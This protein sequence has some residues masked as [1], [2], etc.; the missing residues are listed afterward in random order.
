LLW[1]EPARY[2]NPEKNSEWEVTLYAPEDI[3]DGLGMDNKDANK[4]VAML[5]EMTNSGGTVIDV[6]P[7]W[8]S[9]QDSENFVHDWAI[10]SQNSKAD[11]KSMNVNPAQ[12][13]KGYVVFEIPESAAPKSGLYDPIAG[14]GESSLTIWSN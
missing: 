14:M 2:V 10:V 4:L 7:G 9:L 3:P 6:N 8:F 12:T 13:V 5:V 1:R 11:F